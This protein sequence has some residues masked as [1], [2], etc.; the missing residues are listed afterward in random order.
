MPS[1]HEFPE[2]SRE[3]WRSMAHR[4]RSGLLGFPLIFSV[5][6]LSILGGHAA[7]W[8][9]AL[10]GVVCLLT[11]IRAWLVLR[12]DTLFDAA[13]RRWCSLYLLDL[14]ALTGLLTVVICHIVAVAGLDTPGILALAAAAATAGFGVIVYSYQIAIARLVIALITLPAIV[15]LVQA[16]EPKDWP[17]SSVAGLGMVVYVLY[18]LSVARQLHRERWESLEASRLL[19]LRAAELETAQKEL[20]H[21]HQGLQRKAEE[22]RLAKEAAERADQAKTEFLANMSHEI[23]TPLAGV[24]GLADLLLKSGL[25]GRQ[26]DY[27]TLVQSAGESLLR[28]IDDILDFS[29]IEAG[30]LVL[31]RAPFELRPLM[32]EICDLLRF[33]AQEKGIA[34]GLAVAETAPAWVTG[35]AA[36]LRQVLLNLIGNAIKFTAAGQVDLEVTGGGTEDTHVRF[37]VRDTG[38]GIAPEARDKIFSPFSQEDSST[39]RRFGGTGLGLAISRRIVE[40]MGGEI[41]FASTPGEGSLFWFRLPLTS[42][43]APAAAAGRSAGQPPPDSRPRRILVA[44]DHPINQLVAVRQ[45]EALGYEVMAVSNGIEALAVL[46]ESDY[47]LLLMD[48]QMPEMDG[49][50]TARRLRRRLGEKGSRLPIVALTAHA[51]KEDLERCL[52]AGMDDYITKPFHPDALRRI[53]EK[54]LSGRGSAPLAVAADPEPAPADEPR[55][56][57]SRLQGLR[58]L[59]RLGGSDV[60]A[61]VIARF[62]EQPLLAALRQALESRDRRTLELHAHTLKGSSSALGAPRLA[63]LCGELERMAPKAGLDAC[64][65]QLAAL[66]AEYDEVLAELAVGYP[67]G[68]ALSSSG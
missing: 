9:F 32:R 7:G 16:P 18:L 38:I 48:C 13:P 23:R 4:S 41:G 14:T 24:I 45:L 51:L 44:E 26:R 39:S 30:K 56:D 17:G 64:A 37:Q 29:K 61:S 20:R 10:L 5:L 47:D 2:L 40:Q 1:L 43:A 6:G 62:R 65:C 54:W 49:Y 35:D 15:V 53:V 21:T 63:R 31:E 46:E 22:L 28:L 12:F 60:L 19:A 27:A 42:T 58:E 66:A 55:L 8:F 52:Q 50:E 67:E 59:G 68:E 11:G 36:R 34:L 57:P 33:R 25:E 3:A